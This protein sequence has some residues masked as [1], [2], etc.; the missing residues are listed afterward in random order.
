MEMSPALSK[1]C[2]KTKNTLEREQA[3]LFLKVRETG[4]LHAEHLYWDPRE[5]A[6]SPS[7]PAKLH[8]QEEARS[9]RKCWDMV[10]NRCTAGSEM[11]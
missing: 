4:F 5:P 6:G 8:R 11:N 9:Q 3:W 1:L 7:C 10:Y 2:L